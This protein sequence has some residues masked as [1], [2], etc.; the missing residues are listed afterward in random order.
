MPAAT[1]PDYIHESVRT[2]PVLPTAVTRLLSLAR[3]VNVDFREI[4]RVIET[5]QT[6]TARTLRAAN[7]PLNGVSRPVKTVRQA[8]V[9]LGTD[10]II[11]L[12][13]GVS[14]ISLQSG[15]YK[16]LPVESLSVWVKR[17]K[18]Y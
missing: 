17:T 15:L 7:S 10:T 4:A 11:N 18:T 6:L 1:V 9:L 16:N 13:L 5:D 12:A 14:V 8:T 3:D 2:L